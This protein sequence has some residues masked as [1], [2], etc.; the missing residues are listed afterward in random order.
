M[1]TAEDIRE[2]ARSLAPGERFDAPIGDWLASVQNTAG[3]EPDMDKLATG[4]CWIDMAA[5]GQG[6]V[7]STR[8]HFSLVSHKSACNLH[9]QEKNGPSNYFTTVRDYPDERHF[10][11]HVNLS[12]SPARIVVGSQI[13]GIPESAVSFE[14]SIPGRGSDIIEIPMYVRDGEPCTGFYGYSFESN[15]L[16]RRHWLA[17]DTEFERVSAEHL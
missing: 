7:G 5:T 3:I 2:E 12:K 14:K 9:T 17:S 10:V 11:A 8:P 13:L 1:R 4:S 16:V 15:Q 6:Y